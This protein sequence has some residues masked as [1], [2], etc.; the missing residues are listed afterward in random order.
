[1]QDLDFGSRSLR[2]LFGDDLILSD[3]EFVD[4]YIPYVLKKAGSMK[5][6][7]KS[8]EAN[9]KNYF[10]RMSD[11]EK[12]IREDAKRDGEPSEYRKR[13]VDLLLVQDFLLRG[14]GR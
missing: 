3:D 14:D 11:L 12:R 8:F 4:K 13:A 5:N 6:D 7:D 10:R 1:M 9:L 2:K